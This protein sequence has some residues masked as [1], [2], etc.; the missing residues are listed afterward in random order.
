MSSVPY[1]IRIVDLFVAKS[2]FRRLCSPIFHSCRDADPGVQEPEYRDP[3]KETDFWRGAATEIVDEARKVDS[4]PVSKDLKPVGSYSDLFD[5]K[6]SLYGEVT[7]EPDEIK[8]ADL[9][10]TNAD[11]A[12]EVNDVVRLTQEKDAALVGQSESP[13]GAVEE[14]PPKEAAGLD[15][16]VPTLD[17]GFAKP[18]EMPKGNTEADLFQTI[19][20]KSKPQ[21]KSGPVFQYP[22]GVDRSTFFDDNPEETS[23]WNSWNEALT[24]YQLSFPYEPLIG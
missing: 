15:L 11:V 3:A 18:A 23:A 17:G 21:G 8:P 1:W 9:E 6:S 20:Q 14:K 10:D 12:N 24:R 5:V 7:D 2:A 13:R 19:S 4:S 16:D 22:E